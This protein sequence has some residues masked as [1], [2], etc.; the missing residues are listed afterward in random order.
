MAG[1]NICISYAC[2]VVF[3]VA[4]S[5]LN[6][7]LGRTITGRVTAP[8]SIPV[9]PQSLRVVQ[10][11]ERASACRFEALLVVHIEHTI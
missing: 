8:G 7:P 3:C 9:R 10:S 2:S 5:H 1:D 6:T 4:Y 11:F